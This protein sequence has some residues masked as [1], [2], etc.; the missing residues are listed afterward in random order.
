[1]MSQ[2]RKLA[3]SNFYKKS[4]LTLLRP[5]EQLTA[6]SKLALT[7]LGNE[8][9]IIKNLLSVLLCS[10][11]I[12]IIVSI[13][14]ENLLGIFNGIL[15]LSIACQLGLSLLLLTWQFQPD[16]NFCTCRSN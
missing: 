7:S 9:E 1:M 10:E 2:L 15:N 6:I 12:I 13:D 4:M 5:A 3:V 11:V 14:P 16:Q 8:N